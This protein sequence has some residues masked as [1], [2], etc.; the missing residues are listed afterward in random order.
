[1]EIKR[2]YFNIIKFI[3]KKPAANI[4]LNGQKLSV[5][6]KIKNNTGMSTVLFNIV[7]EIVATEIKQ[8]ELKGIQ[9][10]KEDVKLSLFTDD[11]IWHIENPIVSTKKLLDVINESGK[12][13]GY[14]IN[15]QKL[16]AFLYI[17]NKVPEREIKKTI[18]FTITRKK[19]AF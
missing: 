10:E 12:A 18:L 4:I 13:S 15:T 2:S 16:M 3:Y 19:R 17:N 7:L 11:M 1:M 5:P 9:I 14:K 6:F 8:K